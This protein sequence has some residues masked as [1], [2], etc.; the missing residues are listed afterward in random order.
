MPKFHSDRSINIIRGKNLVGAATKKDVAL[1]LDHIEAL[2][3]FLDRWGEDDRFG[4]EG[5]RHTAG[6][7]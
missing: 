6:L 1:L 7:E 5:W 3:A 4:T 2:E